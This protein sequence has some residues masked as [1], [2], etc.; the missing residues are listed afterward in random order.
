M[1]QC[2]LI[3]LRKIR[4]QRIP[5][6][7][8][9]ELGPTRASY[10][11][12]PSTFVHLHKASCSN[13]QLSLQTRKKPEV[14]TYKPLRRSSPAHTATHPDRLIKRSPLSISHSTHHAPNH[15]R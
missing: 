15:H 14:I 6:F 13:E 10:W 3:E 1:G 11:H 7:F 4:P 8:P 9:T 5:Q 12:I 2:E